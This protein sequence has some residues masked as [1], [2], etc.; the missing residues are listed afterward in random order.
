LAALLQLLHLRQK[1]S[2]WIPPQTA[3][4][5]NQEV[6]LPDGNERYEEESEFASLNDGCVNYA[7]PAFRARI[8][9]L[10]K[11]RAFPARSHENEHRPSYRAFAGTGPELDSFTTWQTLEITTVTVLW[12]SLNARSPFAS[13]TTVERLAP[14]KHLP[15]RR[16]VCGG[17]IYS[18][19]AR[20]EPEDLLNAGRSAVGVRGIH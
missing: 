15:E 19:A 11:L 3:E 1:R 4:V 13:F 10:P 20:R 18:V 5:A 17:G 2:N 7:F 14:A 6:F 16:G 9:K 8:R 12:E